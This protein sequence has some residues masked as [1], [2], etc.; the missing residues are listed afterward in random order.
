MTEKTIKIEPRTVPLFLR[1]VGDFL[2]ERSAAYEDCADVLDQLIYLA[3]IHSLEPVVYYMLRGQREQLSAQRPTELEQMKKAYHGAICISLSQEAAMADMQEAFFEA[4]IPLVA[5]K[6]VQLRELY[7]VPELRTMSDMDCLIQQKDRAK[8]HALMLELGYHCELSSEQVW[9]YRMGTV[10]IEMHTEIAGN[11]IG[12]GFDYC[13]FF[14]DAM[15]H[16]VEQ[17]GQLYLEREYQFCYLIYHIAKHLSS[18]GA[19]VR[20]I[21]DIAAVL[22]HCREEID[23]KRVQELLRASHLWETALAIYG[24]C[25]RWFGVEAPVKGTVSQQ[26]LDDLEAYIVSGGTYGFETHDAGD[27]YRRKAVRDQSEAKGIKYKLR[28]MQTYLFP[29]SDYLFRYFPPAER[30]RWLTP[31]AW[32]CRCW[33]GLFRRKAHSMAT[34]RSIAQGDRQRSYREVLMLREIGL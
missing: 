34:I 16:V 27:V 33:I 14:S 5:F 6:G 2:A 19:G 31:V 15:N 7:P 1:M 20:M 3:R 21:A 22:H 23:W 32:V 28:L 26:V 10:M 30:H 8:A 12:N 25:E 18:T 4:G 9:V 17:G 29:P 13:A 11:G 24:L